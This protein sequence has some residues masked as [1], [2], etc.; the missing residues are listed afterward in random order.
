[1]LEKFM[2]RAGPVMEKVVEEIEQRAAINNRDQAS[3]KSAVE[4][5]SSLKF[6]KEV[7]TLFTLPEGDPKLNRVTCIHMFESSP[8]SKCAV[9]Y[10]L[11]LANGDEAHVIVVYST[12][13]SQMQRLIRS[14]AEVTQMCTSGDDSVLICGSI[15]GSI[16]IYDMQNFDTSTADD[17]NYNALL[18]EQLA[19]G[20]EGEIN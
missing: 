20:G 2:T 5:K 1:M 7:L 8:Q 4:L 18:Q 10:E 16:V 3:K 6:P 19:D 13:A 11:N 9:A 12:T 14:D 17:L 15:Y